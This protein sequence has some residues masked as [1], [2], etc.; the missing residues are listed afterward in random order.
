VLFFCK[1]TSLIVGLKG[2]NPYNWF[3]EGPIRTLRNS[4]LKVELWNCEKS[5]VLIA[6]GVLQENGINSRF[7]GVHQENKDIKIINIHFLNELNF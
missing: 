5:E 4:S 6:L 1:H 7:A 2:S 3:R